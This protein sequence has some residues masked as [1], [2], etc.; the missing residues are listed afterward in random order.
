[1]EHILVYRDPDSYCHNPDVVKLTDQELVMTFR[2]APRRRNCTHIDPESIAPVIRS[3]DGG[4]TWG[5]YVVAAQ[6]P[7]YIGIQDPSLCLL[8][9]GRMLCNF[10]TWDAPPEA[11]YGASVLG[12]FLTVSDD[13]GRTWHPD[14]VEVDPMETPG[15][16]CATTDAVVELPDG[17]LL[18]P[19]YDTRLL[20]REGGGDRSY[21]LRSTDEGRTWHE[22]G[23]IA[24][25]PLGN[26]DF[27]EP[28]LTCLPDGRLVAM[29]REERKK[30]C[31][32]IAT[33][34]D[35]GET[36]TL[37]KR[38]GIWGFPAD[39]L[40]LKSGKLL[41]T[42]GYRRPPYGVRACLSHDGGATWDY[43]NE[44]IIRNDGIGPD[45]GYPSSVQLDDGSIFTA[46][47]LSEAP[48]GGEFGAPVGDDP[49]HHFADRGIRYIAASYYQEW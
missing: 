12:T 46:Y 41:C 43:R 36:W 8:G 45:V 5:E 29:I 25:D 10:F 42:Y 26:V 30:E 9:E 47:Y 21:V 27:A 38:T 31:L 7:G 33:S 35:E 13:Y 2:Q 44:L 40:P 28:A 32:W 20:V 24:Y 3:R 1:M 17:D 4:R 6:G 15:A 49:A 23:T 19:M 11:P 22:W 37:P 34:D 39:L 16:Y 48:E 14:L 18:M